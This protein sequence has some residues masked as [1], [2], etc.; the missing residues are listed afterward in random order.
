MGKHIQ[1]EFDLSLVDEFTQKVSF[2]NTVSA[3]MYLNFRAIRNSDLQ[4]TCAMLIIL[5]AKIQKRH[6]W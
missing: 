3:K 1:V 6:F 5:G 2:F 4:Y